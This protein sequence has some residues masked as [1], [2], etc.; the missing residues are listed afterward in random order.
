MQRVLEKSCRII[1][2]NKFYYLKNENKNILMT[3]DPWLNDRIMDATQK[4]ICKVSGKTDSLQSVLNLQRRSKM[5][6]RAV[7]NGHIQLLHDGNN[8]WLLS[9]CS[10][11]RVEI[12]DSLKNH[13]GRFRLRS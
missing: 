10:S 1:L 12:S 13:A 2:Q 6:F 3:K 8:H 5:P 4:L 11:D 9:F 7:N